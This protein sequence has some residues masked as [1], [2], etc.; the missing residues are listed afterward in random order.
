MRRRSDLMALS[1][2]GCGSAA[3]SAGDSTVRVEIRGVNGRQ[4]KLS[5]RSSEGLASLE[6]R[7]EALAQAIANRHARQATAPS[8]I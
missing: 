6:P 1:M 4:F 2:T 7:I 8:S 3:A 5:L